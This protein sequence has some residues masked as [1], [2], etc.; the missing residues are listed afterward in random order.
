MRGRFGTIATAVSLAALAAALTAVA[1]PAFAQSAANPVVTELKLGAY[2]AGR[3][4]RG[5]N[6][7]SKAAQFY[8]DALARDPANPALL[9]QAFDMSATEGNFTD[10]IKYAERIVAANGDN[11]MA[12]V[13]LALDAFKRGA[14][15]DADTHFKATEGNPVGDLTA[16]IGRAW[17][18]QAT[19]QTK[20]ALEL[21]EHTKGNEG[22]LAFYRYHKA[23][24]N[25][26]AGRKGD[27]RTAY[28]R[29]GKGGENKTLRFAL[30]FAQHASNGGDN[31]AALTALQ[32]QMDRAR[33]DGHPMVR[34]FIK[35]VQDGE[36]LKLIVATPSEGLAEAF[37]GLGEA[38]MS[39]G[40]LGAGAIFLQYALY[41]EPASP[42]ALATLA[43]VFEATKKYDLANAAYD[44]VPKGGPLDTSIE[45][46]KA[47]NLNA[48]EKI[49][50]AKAVLE[51]IIA[52]DPSNLQPL[53]TLG[54]IMRGAKRFDEA[55]TYYSRAITLIGAKPEAKHW[56]YFYARGASYERVK[57]WPLGEQDLLL[58]LKLAPER[59]EVLNY[60]GY[61][62]VDQGK[63]LKQGMAHIEKAVKLKPDD[64]YIVDS[65]G[66]AH[67]KQGNFKDAVKHLE[68]AVELRPEDPVLND[69]LGDAYWRAGREREARFQWEQSLTL[70]PEPE[71][72]DKTESKV[73]NGLPAIAA[74]KPPQTRTKQTQQTEP[75]RRIVR[76]GSRESG[77]VTACKHMHAL[78]FRAVVPE[79]HRP[80]DRSR[81]DRVTAR[82]QATKSLPSRVSVRDS[83]VVLCRV[84]CVERCLVM[85]SHVL[86]FARSHPR[87]SR[88]ARILALGLVGAGL[89]GCAT[90]QS[91]PQYAG[92]RHLPAPIPQHADQHSG[93]ADQ[94]SGK[95][96]VEDDG[97]P[98]QLP[99]A[100]RPLPEEDDPT[101]PWSP[102]YGKK[103][104]TYQKAIA[105]PARTAALS[106][107]A[108]T[109][110]GDNTT[111]GRILRAAEADAIVL[112][113]IQNH[114]ILRP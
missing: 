3:V 39:E 88:L 71:D 46:R 86:R 25:D 102:H 32:G 82:R 42:F 23:L 37:F 98:A 43:N 53:E 60:L 34:D 14:F 4:A 1:A 10:A 106:V 18:R 83:S 56:S 13:M 29:A 111:R 103:P 41:L 97:R 17:I 107:T 113:A 66:W 110:G 47:I 36:K 45:I 48:M 112:R 19:A 96:D 61:S 74:P 51:G 2:M 28:D 15:T 76:H 5:D 62:W 9:S 59:A 16:N 40:G 31:K 55:I 44:R 8:R 26:V 73:K 12:R 93:K 92:A 94:H 30:A 72:K 87:L 95:A 20:E 101:Q 80:F 7:A 69:H 65:L 89:S 22:I 24:L 57:K 38:L 78:P 68:R 64:G 35:R 52:R 77:A 100:R 50:E 105:P 79:D 108:A 54:T 63:N 109:V 58:A 114:E 6:D 49:D 11:R 67:F 27:A 21:L 85:R 33:G 90:S 104:G 81:S 84:C 91:Q 99:P 70:K 75:K